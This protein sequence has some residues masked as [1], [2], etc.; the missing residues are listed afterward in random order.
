[1]TVPYTQDIDGCFARG[2]APEGLPP[3]RLK[4]WL[5]RAGESLARLRAACGDGSAPAFIQLAER[6]DDLEPVQ[7]LARH[8]GTGFDTMLVLG[9]GGSSLGGQ[10]VAALAQRGFGPPQGA[11]EVRFLDN[12][13]PDTFHAMAARLDPAETG[14]LAISKSGGTAETLCQLAI[15]MAWLGAANGDSHL[16][17]HVA[18]MTENLDSPLGQIA[19]DHGLGV[20]DHDPNLG[21]RFSVLS[22]GALPAMLLGLDVHALRAGAAAVNAAAFETDDPTMAPPAQGAAVQVALAREAGVS[23]SVLMP[24]CDR[25]FWFARWYR[26]LWAESLG[27]QGNGTTP[28]DA[29][30]T[31]D[32]HSQLQL[33]LDGPAD[34]LFTL[35]NVPAGELGAAVDPYLVPGADYLADATMGQLFEA[36]AR[37][38]RDS[39]LA[40]G[41]PVRTLDLQALDETRLGALFQHFMLETAIAADLLGVD[42]YDQPAVEDGKQRTK[43]FM[44][45]RKG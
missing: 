32:Q 38:T 1:M 15:V 2:S 24:Y 21:G 25:L 11:P 44:R 12:V 37:A 5:T 40:H 33:Y 23:Q 27:K 30:G 31:V 43:A 35:V 39:L 28:I 10:A 42:A 19:R 13:D 8:F 26:Q 22:T 9:T 6:A 3:E 41:R 7:R 29:I 14:V 20:L 45:E 4:P 16:C 34:K 18:V 36:E 17:Q